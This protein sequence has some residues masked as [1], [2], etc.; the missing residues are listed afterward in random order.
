MDG[1]LVTIIVVVCVILAIV[2]GILLCVWKPKILQI[3][4]EKLVERWNDWKE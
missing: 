4:K 1:A 2:S 3:S